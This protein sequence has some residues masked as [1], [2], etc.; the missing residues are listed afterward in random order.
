MS[1]RRNNKNNKQLIRKS[2]LDFEE[3]NDKK[4]R[5]S[6]KKAGLSPQITEDVISEVQP[7]VKNYFSTQTLHNATYKCLLKK[8]RVVA[9]NYN[10]KQAIYNLGPTGYPFEI[11]CAEM[12]KVKGYKTKVSVI[13][14]GKFVRHEVDVIAKR[15][16]HN[17]Y[18]ECKFHSLKSR[19][20]NIKVPLYVQSRYVDIQAGNPNEKFDYAIFSNTEFSKDAIQYSK[21]MGLLL[22][23][24]NYPKRGAF[25][26]LVRRYKVFPITALKS[27]RVRDRKVL[28]ADGIVVIKR[29]KRTHLLKLGLSEREISKVFQEIKILTH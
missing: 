9:A 2:S 18:C 17:I 13:K 19:K 29:V 4:F 5:T 23:S 26:D 27:L 3:F 6:L 22:F 8:S 15:D 14:R 7:T 20:N 25:I 10:I 16:D 11:F 21:G 12:L 24:M 28:L 1:K